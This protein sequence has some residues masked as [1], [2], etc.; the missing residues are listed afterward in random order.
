M[1]ILESLLKNMYKLI[2]FRM[3]F[4]R[5][6]FMYFVL[7]RRATLAK[8]HK[9]LPYVHSNCKILGICLFE[10]FWSVIKLLY[11]LRQKKS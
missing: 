8:T 10:L 6:D 3:S 7:P 5:L 9:I 11:F 1:I 2:L 4:L